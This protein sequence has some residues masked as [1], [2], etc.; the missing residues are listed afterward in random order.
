[1]ETTEQTEEQII[2][3][4]KNKIFTTKT[5]RKEEK[6]K[7]NK[8]ATPQKWSDMD[9]EETTHSIR[10]D[11][12]K[13]RNNSISTD[14]REIIT[15]HGDNSTQDVTQEEI[16]NDNEVTRPIQ[17]K[18]KKQRTESYKVPEGYES[19]NTRSKKM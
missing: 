11:G 14:E 13:L 16:G 7:T 9:Q 19:R 8:T 17:T 18:K 12:V 3:E 10:V 2:P 15:G 5:E 6:G 1:M 4:S